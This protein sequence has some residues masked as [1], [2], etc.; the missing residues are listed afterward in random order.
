MGLAHRSQTRA[1]ITYGLRY[2]H[3]RGMLMRWLKVVRQP[4]RPVV[5]WAGLNIYQ[6][7]QL[8]AK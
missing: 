8:A 7:R 6:Q 1:I 5:L 3:S 2:K 4:C